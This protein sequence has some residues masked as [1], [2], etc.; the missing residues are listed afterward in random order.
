MNFRGSRLTIACACTVLIGLCMASTGDAK[1]GPESIVGL[2]PFDEGEGEIARDFSGKEHDGNLVGDVT[3]VQGRFGDALSFPGIVGSRMNVPHK[4]SLDLVT[5]TMTMWMNLGD[6][7]DWQY[8]FTKESPGDLRNYIIV[9]ANTGQGCAALSGNAW[10]GEQVWSKT[11]L[12]DD[13]W[14][15]VAATY[16]KTTLVLYIDGIVE[17]E[18]SVTTTPIAN[19]VDVVLGERFNGSQPVKGIIDELG[20]F[21]RA[22]TAD[23]VKSLMNDGFDEGLGLTAVSLKGKLT[24]SWGKIRGTR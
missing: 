15:H 11:K 10:K 4:K 20:L 12:H 22:L 14:H 5:W 7:G 19:E 24:T 16:D 3:W 17:G 9:T 18:L 23:E 8:I 13:K 2:W 6:S 21:N 1:I